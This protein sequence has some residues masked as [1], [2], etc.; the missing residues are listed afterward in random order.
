MNQFL[1]HFCTWWN[2]AHYSR[3]TVQRFQRT[4]CGSMYEHCSQSTPFRSQFFL[5]QLPYVFMK[6]IL[7]MLHDRLLLTESQSS[8]NKLMMINNF[9][10]K[11][12]GFWSKKK[13]PNYCRS[14]EHVSCGY[15]F[16]CTCGCYR[17]FL[18]QKCIYNVTHCWL[19][20]TLMIRE[21][22]G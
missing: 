21:V 8:L 7:C 9:I 22:S 12:L 6:S 3:L 13:K 16:K 10:N 4:I 18:V 20:L 17:H 2:H 14:S 1:R 5:Q 15:S 19:Q 11:S